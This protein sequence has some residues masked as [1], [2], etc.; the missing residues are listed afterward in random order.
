MP[1]DVHDPRQIVGE[2]ERAVSVHLHTCTSRHSSRSSGRRTR[3]RGSASGS[4]AKAM[5]F[6]G[7]RGLSTAMKRTISGCFF[8]R[9]ISVAAFERAAAVKLCAYLAMSM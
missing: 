9:A 6:A 4:W 2:A 5:T 3:S 8:N 1:M 7:R